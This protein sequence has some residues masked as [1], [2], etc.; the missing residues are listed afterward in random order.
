[1]AD[2]TLLDTIRRVRTFGISMAKL[3]CRQES[4]RHAEALDYVTS[5][6]GLGSYLGWDE[7]RRIGW[8][9]TEL[10]SA[11]PLLPADT[12]DAPEKVAGV[13]ATFRTFYR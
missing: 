12:S 1:M 10:T 7:D 9:T 2:G 6:L 3:D 13:L 5:A 11:R 8:L 4:D